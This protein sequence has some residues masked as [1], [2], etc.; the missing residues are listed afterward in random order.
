MSRNRLIIAAVALMVFIWL[1]MVSARGE[2]CSFDLPIRA[3]LH[4]I[5]CGPVTFAM[6]FITTFG[7]GIALIPCG[8]ILVW[9][10]AITG[11]RHAALEF[12]LALLTA[13]TAS[14]IFKAL[15]ARPRPEL[16]FDLI[17]ADNFSF[18]SGHAFVGTVFYAVL[19][20]VTGLPRI[21]PVIIALLIG[22][23]RVYLGYHYPSDVLGGYAL[24]VLWIVVATR[25]RTHHHPV[26]KKAP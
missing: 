17:P 6:R 7:G 15:W 18:P 25:R 21:V 16:F 19:A 9:R 2:L 13:E 12:G 4:K 23:S 5:A 24:A 1:A 11:R 22:S 20:D 14:D 3:A 8:A 10:W 26:A